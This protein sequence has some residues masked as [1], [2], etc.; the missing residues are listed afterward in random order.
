[1]DQEE[2][3]L[4]DFNMRKQGGLAVSNIQ[5]GIFPLG[6]MHY[7]TA[8]SLKWPNTFFTLSHHSPQKENPIVSKE[9]YFFISKRLY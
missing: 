6:L 5:P 8:L 3:G 9:N 1:M 2:K 4:N 7:G